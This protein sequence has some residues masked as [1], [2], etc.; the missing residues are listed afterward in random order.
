MRIEIDKAVVRA[1]ARHHPAVLNGLSLSIADQEFLAIVGPS[2]CG[3]STLL[4]AI[5]G[6][7]SLSGGTIRFLQRGREARP[8][9]LMAFQDHRLFPWLTALQNAALGLEAQGVPKREREARAMEYLARFGLEAAA[10]QFPD[11]L[12]GGMKQR[13]SLIRLMVSGGD[14]MLFDEPLAALD[15]QNRIYLQ[16][17]LLDFWEEERKTSV[18]VTHDIE[19]ALFLA[20]R[21]IV[22]DLKAEILEDIEVPAAV[23]KGGLGTVNPDRE[24]LRWR[25]WDLLPRPTVGGAVSG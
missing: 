13:I 17:E 20:S 15:A 12:S 14:V 25:I 3:K 10:D 6:L 19:E 21:V 1:G 2:G 16:Q 22:L 24:A 8:R 7:R 5:G 11:Q 4:G 9:C 23:R 18:F